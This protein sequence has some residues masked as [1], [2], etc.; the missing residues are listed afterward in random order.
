MNNEE[1]NQEKLRQSRKKQWRALR[2][3]CLQHYSGLTVPICKCCGENGFDFLHLDHG[4]GNGAEHRRELKK[5]GIDGGTGFYGWLKRNNW[6]DNLGLQILCAN[7]DFGK[8]DKQYCPHELLRGVDLNGNPIPKLPTLNELPIPQ[9]IKHI[10]ET[11]QEYQKRWRLE[12][13]DRFKIVQKKAALAVQL[14]CFQHYSKLKIPVC[15][16]CNESILEFLQIDHTDGNGAQHRKE[17]LAKTGKNILG[18]VTFAY[19]LKKNNWPDEY[20]LQILC[21]NCNFGKRIGKYCPHELLKGIDLNG[22]KIPDSAYYT[23]QINWMPTFKGTERE[24]WLESP[25]G[26]RFRERNSAAKKGKPSPKK[27]PRTEVFCAQCNTPLQRKPCEIKRQTN[28]DGIA[29][30]FCNPTCAGAW[31]K[32]NAVGVKVYNFTPDIEAP[33]GFCGK[34]LFRKAHQMRQTKEKTYQKVYCNK[35]CQRQNQIGRIPWNKKIALD[36]QSTI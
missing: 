26:L 11:K 8:K 17:T 10:W 25:E 28:K 9:T 34:T 7:C 29:R 15:R 33:C 32:T 19:W 35:K 30:F 21:V 6:P 12:N 13:K 27:M 4:F 24:A 31:K 20:P 2:Q 36:K 16:C 5:I 23:L 18:G 14:E 1:Y 3:D 22:N